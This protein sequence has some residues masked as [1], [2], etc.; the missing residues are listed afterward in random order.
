[1]SNDKRTIGITKDNHLA[2]QKLVQ[3]GQ[4]VSELDAAKFA[5]AHAARSGVAV[6][7]A[8]GADTKWNVGSVDPTGDLR[9]MIISLYPDTKEPY[10]LIEYLMNRGISDLAD[11]SETPDVFGLLFSERDEQP[12]TNAKD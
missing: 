9:E 3:S 12:T 7:H 1:M 4:F 5:M 8:D 11:A 2:L 6:G 10:R